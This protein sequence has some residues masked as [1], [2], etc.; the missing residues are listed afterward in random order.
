[1]VCECDGAFELTLEYRIR[2]ADHTR[3]AFVLK[4]NR[5]YKKGDE[6]MKHS[7]K[8]ETSLGI[9][10]V[11]LHTFFL[12][13]MVVS[14]TLVKILGILNFDNHW[15]DVTVPVSFSASIIAFITGI[16]AVRKK[17]EHSTLVFLSILLGIC[18][19]LFLLTHSLFIN[20]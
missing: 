11:G 18:V 2:L 5:T 20:D 3:S 12:I 8:P 16:R 1:V 6:K 7:L 4:R 13:T 17:N 15:W 10:S 9:W 19:I 14:V